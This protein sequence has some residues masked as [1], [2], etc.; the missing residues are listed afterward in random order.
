MDASTATGILGAGIGVVLLIWLMIGLL[1]G[2][3]VGA[4][5]RFLLPGPDP[6]SWIR[7]LG[8]GIGGSFLGGLVGRLLKVPQGL[9]FVLAVACAAALIWFF[10]RRKT[11][12]SLPSG[13]DPENS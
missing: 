8:Y 10:T 2:L 13:P 3:V 5:A 7:T 11:T 6:M 12:P 4:L 9:D 1:S